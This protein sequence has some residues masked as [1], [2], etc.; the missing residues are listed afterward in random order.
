M[1]NQYVG[2]YRHVKPIAVGFSTWYFRQCVGYAPRM[3]DMDE[4]D[5]RSLIATRLANLGISES[6]FSEML[7]KDR[8]Y[9]NTYMK[10]RSPRKLAHEDKVAAARLLKLSRK[11]LGVEDPPATQVAPSG[12]REDAASYNVATTPY[13]TCPDHHYWYVMR[14]LCLDQ[15]PERI[16][17]GD[18]LLVDLNVNNH[19]RLKTGDV[20][21]V[22][23]I[24]KNN[25]DRVITL[26]RE[27]VAP[28]KAITNSSAENQ[29]FSFD[30]DNLDFDHVIRG[31]VVSITRS[32]MD[33]GDRGR[34][35]PG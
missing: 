32:F 12:F 2:F 18:R 22:S 19:A 11:E 29:I 5:V 10:R 28:N 33:D 17:P 7:G 15:H 1:S 21:V 3:N 24:S 8:S 25:P 13:L 30:D 4:D 31:R 14:T 34:D 20:I 27:F 23:A 16:K 26:V 35:R 6:K 9:I